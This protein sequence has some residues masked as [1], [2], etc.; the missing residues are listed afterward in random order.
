MLNFVEEDPKELKN[1]RNDDPII[2]FL[3][4]YFHRIG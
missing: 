1:A 3:F 4:L 2:L